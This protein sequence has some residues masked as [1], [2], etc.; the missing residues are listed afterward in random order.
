MEGT[1]IFEATDFPGKKTFFPSS[2]TDGPY[3]LDEKKICINTQI[4]VRPGTVT[5]MVTYPAPDSMKHLS[6]HPR[7]CVL[8]LSLVFFFFYHISVIII[9]LPYL[10]LA[11]VGA[12]GRLFKTEKKEKE[13]D[14]LRTSR[15]HRIASVHLSW[16]HLPVDYCGAKYEIT[17]LNM[18]QTGCFWKWL[19][20][21]VGSVGW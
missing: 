10:T 6:F 3:A 1:Q 19:N 17:A 9:I 8:L 15:I 14:F 13:S 7:C 12:L 5:I 4:T 11:N 2:H 21:K 16:P 18:A 20:V